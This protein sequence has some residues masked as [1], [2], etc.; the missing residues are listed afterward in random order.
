MKKKKY[1]VPATVTY[2]LPVRLMVIEGSGQYTIGGDGEGEPEDEDPNG[3]RRD[4]F[5][6]E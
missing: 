4:F 6:E 2:K 3:T 1:S 5:G